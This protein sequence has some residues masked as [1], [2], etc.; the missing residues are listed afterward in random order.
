MHHALKTATMSCVAI[1]VAAS[2]SAQRQWTITGQEV[3]E[4]AAVDQMMLEI[5]QDYDIRGGSAIT[6]KP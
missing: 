6:M 5:M 1:M 3:P 2:V 4:L